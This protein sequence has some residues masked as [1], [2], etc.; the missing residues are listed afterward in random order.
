[1]NLWAIA[2]SFA[3]ALLSALGMGGGGIFIVYL[4]AAAG[5]D[6]L[7]AQGI[8]LLFFI[9][10]AAVAVFIHAR[11]KLIRWKI[12]LPCVIFGICGVYLGIKLAIY[13]GADG[14]SMVFGVLLLLIGAQGLLGK[15]R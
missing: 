9:P 6:Q 14:L 1:M 10:I 15:R 2:A 12:V 13:I 7:A 4:T 5:Y 8:N 11:N 3:G